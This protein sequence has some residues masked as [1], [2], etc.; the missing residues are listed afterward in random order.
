MALGMP[1][2]FALIVCALALML[3]LG[4]FDSQIV[5]QNM[6]MGANTSPLL[7]SPL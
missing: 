1:I 5:A 4:N 6:I 7:P 3:W 2:A